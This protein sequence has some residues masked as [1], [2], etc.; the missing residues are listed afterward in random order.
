[1]K[2]ISILRFKRSDKIGFYV[3]IRR[4]HVNDPTQNVIHHHLKTE[5]YYTIS[6]F[7][8]ERRVNQLEFMV[9]KALMM[10]TTRPYSPNYQTDDAVPTFINLAL[11]NERERETAR[12]RQ[13]D[14]Q[15]ERKKGGKERPRERG[16]RRE[17]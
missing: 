3:L 2:S 17:T 13:R 9:F 10:D 4:G 7:V 5:N 11:E 1:M 15:R 14:N 8:S 12:E 6:T 16:R